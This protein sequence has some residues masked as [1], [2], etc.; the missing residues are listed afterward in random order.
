M[1]NIPTPWTKAGRATI[2]RR[3]FLRASAGASAM[4][5]VPSWLWGNSAPDLVLIMMA[6]L[7]SGYP[8]TAALLQSVKTVI[9]NSP[10]SDVR[11]IVNG[12]VFESG[13]FLS[14]LTTPAGS[15]DNQMLSAYAN[16]A[17]TIAT[18][19]NHDGDLFDPRMY[20]SDLNGI[21]M[22]SGKGLTLISN[23]GDTRN[24]NAL[25]ANAATAAFTVRGNAVKVAAIG[26]PSNSYANNALYYRPNPGPYAAALFPTLFTN[27]DFHLALVHAG[28]VQDTN[29]L[30]YLKPPFLLQGG[31]DHLRFTQPLAG[32]QGLHLHAGYWSNGLAVVGINFHANGT[33]QMRPVQIQLNRA[34]PAD[35]ALAGTI[36]TAESTL[37]NPTNNP[38]VGTSSQAYDLDT[39]V[40]K[41]TGVVAEVAGADI[42]FLSH[43]TFGDGLPQGTV[44]TLAFHAFIRF[45]GGFALADIPGSQLLSQILPI[46]NQYGNFPYAKRTGDFLYTSAQPADIDPNKTYRCIVNSFAASSAYFGTP[47]PAFTA[48]PA[49]LELRTIVAGVLVAG[50]VY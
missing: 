44:S 32:G 18:I 49:G 46:T 11:I 37:L 9:S 25:Y 42:G 16:L 13:N 22:S 29:V 10:Y 26:T 31:H 6:D 28:F 39:A 1:L 36:A 24:N 45:P 8:Y 2:A 48:A 43:T 35:A 23:L 14:S 30:P 27:S 47:S 41:T 5:M 15:I 17:P 21:G 40:I 33:V 20:V 34:S 19:G 12:D 3:D 50:G 38:V 4:A 7:H